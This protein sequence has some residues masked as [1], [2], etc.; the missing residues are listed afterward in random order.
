[1]QEDQLEER[2]INIHFAGVAKVTPRLGQHAVVVVVVKGLE[3]LWS[4]YANQRGVE[5]A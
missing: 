2:F 1:M 3:R 5:P 4:T